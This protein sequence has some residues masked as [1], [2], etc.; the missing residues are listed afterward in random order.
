ME[1]TLG[2][3]LGQSWQ[4]D[5]VVERSLGE[6]AIGD[7]LIR[8]D[9]VDLPCRMTV[10][11]VAKRC[12]KFNYKTFFTR[13]EYYKA[14]NFAVL[15]CKEDVQALVVSGQPGI[16]LFILHPTA[17]KSSYFYQKNMFLFRQCVLVISRT[18]TRK[19]VP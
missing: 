8:P 15:Q 2:F 11:D 17:T 1:V 7:A 12:R 5:H 3:R 13:S 16:G 18:Q 14:E 6:D 10:P 9:D 19:K 4:V